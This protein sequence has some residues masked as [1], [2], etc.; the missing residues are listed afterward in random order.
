MDFYEEVMPKA[1]KKLV[2]RHDSNELDYID[3]FTK[4]LKE[5]GISVLD[6]SPEN[7][8]TIELILTDATPD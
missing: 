2:F 6:V 3:A 4:A 1:S 5:F 7:G 8:E